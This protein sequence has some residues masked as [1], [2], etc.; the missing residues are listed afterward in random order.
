MDKIDSPECSSYFWCRPSEVDSEASSITSPYSNNVFESEEL[1]Y[2]IQHSSSSTTSSP[3]RQNSNDNSGIN[4]PQNGEATSSVFWDDLHINTTMDGY[5]S[6]SNNNTPTP[7]TSSTSK[8]TMEAYTTDRYKRKQ[9]KMLLVSLIESFC[10]IYGDSPDANRK[11]FFLICQTLK[12]LGIIDTEFIDEMASVRSTFQRTF[13]KLFYAALHTVQTEPF[14]DQP[15]RLLITTSNNEKSNNSNSNNNSNISILTS[16]TNSSNNTSTSSSA[17]SSSSNISASTISI[18]PLLTPS[19]LSSPSS[20][21]DSSSTMHSATSSS[22]T[23]TSSK[24]VLF[25]L[26]IHHSRY[27]NDFVELCLLGRG[28]FAKAYKVKNKLDGIDYAIKK[29]PLGPD[30]EIQQQQQRNGLN[31]HHNTTHPYKKIFR[32][33]KHLARLEHPNVIRYYASWLEY[34]NNRSLDDD[35]DDEEDLDEEEDSYFHSKYSQDLSRSQYQKQAPPKKKKKELLYQQGSIST[36]TSPTK[37]SI[38][39]SMVPG[40][41]T[42][43]IQMQLCQTTLHDYIEIRNKDYGVVDPQRNIALFTQILL[44]TAYIHEQGLIHRD[45]KPSNIFLT[46]PTP[47]NLENRMH[48]Q[49]RLEG[50]DQKVKIIKDKE[51][52]NDDNEQE[53]N[54]ENDEDE[55]EAYLPSHI[56]WEE[57]IPKIG[58]FGLAAQLM[59]EDTFT[60]TAA[61]TT[62][63]NNKNN[64]NNNALP[65]PTLKD[66][67]KSSRKKSIPLRRTPTIGVG[68]R[69]YA[70]PEQLAFSGRAY[71]EK[72]DIYSLGIILFE[73]YQPFSTFMERADAINN[74]KNAMLPDGF[75]EKYPKES[76]LILWMTDYNPS[77]RPSVHQILD[78]DLFN[79]PS[80]DMLATL[81]AKLKAK[82][83]A[84]HSKNKQVEDLQIDMKRM[85]EE[86]QKEKEEMQKKLDELQKKLDRIVCK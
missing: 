11:V 12:S 14:L 67:V 86:R 34:E 32:E 31:H 77:R 83:E 33:I 40:G 21:L 41:W 71:N 19:A 69:T 7:S 55:D 46:L 49:K 38:P 16:F 20:W 61:A 76:A 84:L 5:S 64:N 17:N 44:G 43:F 81:T 28:G 48:Q 73:L 59:D 72:V 53:E 57:C 65:S 78:Y 2:F 13:Q 68:T 25:D 8:A 85:E 74:L 4:S 39:K 79:Q 51:E 1:S 10:R 9:T 62:S 45:L 42:L 26:S 23:A 36:P 29:V 47:T 6:A 63:S 82:S 52:D 22:A 54:D 60:T 58:D 30:L 3:H 80:T 27:H 24:K 56:L 66:I 75:V 15:Q 50:Y 70:S 37:I 18:N 35:E